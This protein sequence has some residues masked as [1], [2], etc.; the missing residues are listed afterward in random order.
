MPPMALS[1]PNERTTFQSMLALNLQQRS[2]VA[3]ACGIATAATEVVIP[4]R[5][6][7]RGV[8]RLP[9]PNPATDA[10]APLRIAT[11]STPTRNVIR[12]PTSTDG[13]GAA[14][15]C[16]RPLSALR[17][18][19]LDVLGDPLLSPIQADAES[20]HREHE[21][22]ED[23]HLRAEEPAEVGECGRGQPGDQLLE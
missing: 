8:S 13:R 5:V 14:I 17:R 23:S 22:H 16:R 21:R 6:A 20:D 11:T 4:I 19:E 15:S 18:G 1:T 2:A 9:I 10:V 12:Y 7:K 3:S